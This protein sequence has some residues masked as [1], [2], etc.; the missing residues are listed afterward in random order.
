MPTLTLD[1][2]DVLVVQV[3]TKFGPWD[4]RMWSLNYL[5]AC[6]CYLLLNFVLVQLNSAERGVAQVLWTFGNWFLAP[7]GCFCL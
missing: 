2:W 1:L 3:M 6:L 5:H 7:V 4:D